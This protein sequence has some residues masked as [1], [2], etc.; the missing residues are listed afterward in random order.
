MNIGQVWIDLLRRE[1]G[2]NGRRQTIE[3]S[4]YSYDSMTG[5]LLGSP[6]TCPDASK[7]YNSIASPSCTTSMIL[8]VLVGNC[9]QISAAL[10]LIRKYLI[11]HMYL[12]WIVDHSCGTETTC[13]IPLSRILRPRCY[14]VACNSYLLQVP[15]CTVPCHKFATG[16]ILL[17]SEL[18]FHSIRSKPFM[19]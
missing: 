14:I 5:Y 4:W 16:N 19:L 15:P 3:T 8:I 1:Y 17:L 6:Y 7:Q 18:Y 9:T 11:I 2:Q 12:H 10:T 13:S